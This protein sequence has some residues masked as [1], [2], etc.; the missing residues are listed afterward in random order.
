MKCPF[1]IENNAIAKEKKH[2]KIIKI[3][4]IKKKLFQFKTKGF[5]SITKKKKSR[6]KTLEINAVI[7]ESGNE[8]SSFIFGVCLKGV[9]FLF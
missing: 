8:K 9:F 4:K 3:I 1:V 2:K 7:A 5:N 6:N